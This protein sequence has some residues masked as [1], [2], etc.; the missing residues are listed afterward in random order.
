MTNPSEVLTPPSLTIVF[1]S[2][3]MSK[4]YHR[5][6]LSTFFLWETANIGLKRL[7]SEDL[8]FFFFLDDSLN[9]ANLLESGIKPKV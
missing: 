2:S 8:N 5:I 6:G 1:L 9:K 4:V 3:R 7:F